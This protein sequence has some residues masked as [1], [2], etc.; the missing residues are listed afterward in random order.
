MFTLLSVAAV[1][2]TVLAG[3]VPAQATRYGNQDVRGDIESS[4]LRLCGPSGVLGLPLTSELPTPDRIGRYNAFQRGSIYWTPGTG[5]HEVHGD[6]R[7]IWAGTGWELGVLGYPVT[8]ET[9][10]PSRFGRYN[11]FQRGSIYWSPATGAHEVY[12]AIRDAWSAT[13]WESGALGFPTS[14]EISIP[15]GRMNTFQGGDITWTPGG[16]AVVHAYIPVP[17]SSAAPI[18]ACFPPP[19]TSP[20]AGQPVWGVYLAVAPD[21]DDPRLA[22][23][24]RQANAVGYQTDLLSLGCDYGAAEGLGLDPSSSAVAV[25]FASPGQAQQFVDAFQPEVVGTVR[26]VQG[27]ND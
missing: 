17:A 11:A 2:G 13:G 19:I 27:C 5:A 3:T 8:D 10:T 7:R 20:A 25:Y 6:I 12:G 22:E 9:S 21:G 24:E 1:T 18:P 26:I 4:Y 15:G 23:A 16:G 14:G